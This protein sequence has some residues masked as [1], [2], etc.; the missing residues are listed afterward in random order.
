M[1]GTG[2]FITVVTDDRLAHWTKC[3]HPTPYFLKICFNHIHHSIS[4]FCKWSPFRS[5]TTDILCI[6]YAFHDQ[7]ISHPPLPLDFT[8]LIMFVYYKLRNFSF[9]IFARLLLTPNNEHLAS[10]VSQKF[11]DGSGIALL[12]MMLFVTC[13]KM[14]GQTYSAGNRASNYVNY[15]SG[16]KVITLNGMVH[17]NNG[18]ENICYKGIIYSCNSFPYHL[19]EMTGDIRNK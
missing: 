3:T 16:C 14:E 8:I 12:K 1:C 19:S 15:N 17:I 10:H 18:L 11:C 2:K 6:S 7:F 13:I 5:F 9:W 4:W